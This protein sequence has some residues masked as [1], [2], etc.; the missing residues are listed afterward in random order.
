MFFI[1]LIL[2]GDIISYLNV[3]QCKDMKK[4]DIRAF[5]LLKVKEILIL[6][7]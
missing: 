3:L 5:L 6:N 7:L 2:P 4:K 1:V